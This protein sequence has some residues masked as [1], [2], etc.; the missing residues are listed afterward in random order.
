MQNLPMALVHSAQDMAFGHDLR[1]TTILVSDFCD[2][3]TEQELD[4]STPFQL[5]GKFCHPHH[6]GAA[7]APAPVMHLYR[8]PILD[9][10]AESGKD[11]NRLL[12]AYLIQEISHMAGISA[13]DATQ[14]QPHPT[15]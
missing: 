2:E 6:T 7:Y 8:R 1:S 4:L 14:D 11:L 13:E 15:I 3:Q 10:W 5:L 12:A 9:Y